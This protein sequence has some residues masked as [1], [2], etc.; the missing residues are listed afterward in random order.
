MLVEYQRIFADVEKSLRKILGTRT[1]VILPDFGD[2]YRKHFLQLLVGNA[3]NLGHLGSSDQSRNQFS[4]HATPDTMTALQLV[5]GMRTAYQEEADEERTITM[6]DWLRKIRNGIEGD[7]LQSTCWFPSNNTGPDVLFA[8][9]KKMPET[10]KDKQPQ[11]LTRKKTPEA[12]TTLPRR[13][14]AR[15]HSGKNKRDSEDLGP[16]NYSLV[17][18]AVQVSLSVTHRMLCSRIQNSH[19]HS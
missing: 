2:D 13:Y 7:D 3:Q 6:W 17:L 19:I 12:T 1:N 15:Q 10:P 11:T 16:L 14:P 18:C 8:M 4:Q 5:E 9:K